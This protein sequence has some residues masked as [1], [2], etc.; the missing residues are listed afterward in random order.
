MAS[1]SAKLVTTLKRWRAGQCASQFCK[2]PYWIRVTVAEGVAGL[3]RKH[4][5]EWVTPHKRADNEGKDT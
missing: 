3:C 5:G 2:K 1:V 4:Y